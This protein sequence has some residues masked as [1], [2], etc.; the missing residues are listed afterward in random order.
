MIENTKIADPDPLIWY[1]EIVRYGLDLASA[2]DFAP[3]RERLHARLEGNPDLDAL[4]ADVMENLLE[5][6]EVDEG[7]LQDH[8]GQGLEKWWWH[9][10]ALRRG[11]YPA[12][13]LPG[14]LR[15]IYLAARSHRL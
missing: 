13:H 5:L 10:G 14:P 11:S 12:D 15:A 7:W 6:P 9:L 2:P 4:D 1:R 8:P 3:E